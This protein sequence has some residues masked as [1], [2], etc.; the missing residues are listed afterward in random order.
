MLYTPF[1]AHLGG[2]HPVATVLFPGNPH[3]HCDLE[4]MDLELLGTCSMDG[5]IPNEII[6]TV[7]GYS[8]L[9][10]SFVN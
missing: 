3:I 6:V 1:T 8:N 2:Q 10:C 5:L 7:V 9:Y 4:F